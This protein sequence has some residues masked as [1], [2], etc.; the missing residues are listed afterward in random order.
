M[1]AAADISSAQSADPL[2]MQDAVK[3]ANGS[4]K[5]QEILCSMEKCKGKTEESRKNIN[6]NKLWH[7]KKGITANVGN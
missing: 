2:A 4:G 5:L 6:N 3:L 1:A 7:M